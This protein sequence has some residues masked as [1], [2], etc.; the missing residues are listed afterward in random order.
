MREEDIRMQEL[1]TRLVAT[2]ALK[3]EQQMLKRALLVTATL[4]A[5]IYLVLLTI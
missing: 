4:V 5:L 1:R 3:S 2:A